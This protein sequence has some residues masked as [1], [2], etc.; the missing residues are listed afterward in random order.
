MPLIKSSSVRHTSK[1]F[2][3]FVWLCKTSLKVNEMDI[4]VGS[5]LFFFT[6]FNADLYLTLIYLF[7]IQK[8]YT[9]ANIV[10]CF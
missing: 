10:G 8:K 6:V 3:E 4:W 5:C 7:Y 1:A 2:G 9:L